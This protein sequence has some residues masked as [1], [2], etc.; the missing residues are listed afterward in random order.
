MSDAARISSFE[1][2][3]DRFRPFGI[4]KR[5]WRPWNIFRKRHRSDL[6]SSTRKQESAS[7]FIGK[8]QEKIGQE[9]VDGL[10]PGVAK[11]LVIEL[12]E[13]KR[14]VDHWFEGV[15]YNRKMNGSP[16]LE[17]DLGEP[18]A[19]VKAWSGSL[20]VMGREM[21]NDETWHELRKRAK[22]LGYQ[23]RLLRPI[24][25]GMMNV[26]VDQIDQLTD[27]LGDA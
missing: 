16:S 11:K 3:G 12:R 1:T 19:K 22:A 15:F 27:H 13:A 10:P 25:P 23:L 6:R 4:L 8:F 9:I 17:S 14:H 20:R 7:A 24:W 21:A 5:S 26:F 18:I 2:L